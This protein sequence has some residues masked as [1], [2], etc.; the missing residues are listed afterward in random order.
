[1]ESLG[2]LQLFAITEFK[3]ALLI[4]K[5]VFLQH[6]PCDYKEESM[7]VNYV[8]VSNKNPTGRVGIWSHSF[9]IPYLT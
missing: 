1:M 9:L 8:I 7:Y 6:L 3:C 5:S 4:I 2:N